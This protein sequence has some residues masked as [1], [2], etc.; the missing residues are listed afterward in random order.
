MLAFNG[1]Y[2]VWLPFVDRE[3]QSGHCPD[4]FFLFVGYKNIRVA[5]YFGNGGV[6]HTV[7]KASPPW[8]FEGN[9]EFYFQFIQAYSPYF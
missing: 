2:V 7:F 8:V 1:D 9:T 6:Y 3:N 4:M 5:V